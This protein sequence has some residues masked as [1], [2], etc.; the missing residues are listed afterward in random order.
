MYFGQQNLTA[1]APKDAA[2]SNQITSQEQMNGIT[3]TVS[4]DPLAATDS[5]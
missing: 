1:V 5:T 2:D 4:T 3:Y